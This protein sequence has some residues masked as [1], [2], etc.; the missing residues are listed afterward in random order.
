[1]IRSGSHAIHQRFFLG[2][3]VVAVIGA[4]QEI[5]FADE[6]RQVWNVFIGLA[7]DIDA[8]ISK[9]FFA[10]PMFP[11]GVWKRRARAR[12]SLQMMIEEGNPACRCFEEPEPQ[13]GKLLGNLT[14]DQISET[15]D[16]RQV[17]R[18][19]CSIQLEVEKVEQV[20]ATLPGVDADRHV[21]LLRRRIDRMKMRIIQRQ[22]ADNTAEKNPHGAVLFGFMHLR[23]GFFHR[24]QRQNSDP[25][26][27]VISL[28]V[29]SSHKLVVGAARAICSA[30]S[31]V[32][33]IRNKVG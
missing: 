7:C 29:H 24:F 17:G 26:E 14:R 27:P 30:R 8:V 31:S 1:M 16:R 5:I 28:A 25:S 18:S 2:R 23:D 12:R 11:A 10:G 15:D 13:I 32:T 9:E 4:Y 33:W 22:M 3:I 19:E 6:C 20:P 21:E